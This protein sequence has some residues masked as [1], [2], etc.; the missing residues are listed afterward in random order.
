MVYK[1]CNLKEY[2]QFCRQGSLT[3]GIGLVEDGAVHRGSEEGVAE[4][5][6]KV[7]VLDLVLETKQRRHFSWTS[8]YR[9]S[10]DYFSAG[11]R[12]IDQAKMTF[13]LNLVL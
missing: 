12:S 7:L 2:E 10:N 13:Q 9:P 3:L 4:L 6:L 11:P 8:F 5:Q 1:Y